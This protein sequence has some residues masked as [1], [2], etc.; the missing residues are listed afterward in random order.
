MDG[1][2]VELVE[3]MASADLF[4]R[5]FTVLELWCRSGSVGSSWTEQLS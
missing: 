4:M 2:R 5:M 1:F 3:F